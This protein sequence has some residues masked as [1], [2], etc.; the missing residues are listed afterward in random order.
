MASTF[1]TESSASAELL[2]CI[3]EG[4]PWPDYLLRRAL[5]EDEG[6]QLFSVVIERL[7]D[8]FEPALCDEYASLFT[9]VV[10]L[11]R[12]EWK[13]SDLLSRYERVRRIRRCEHTNVRDVFVLSR[14]TLGADV[15][16][17]SVILDAL[18]RR[19]PDANI[20]FTGPRK[21][22]EL[23]AGNRRI[24]HAPYPYPRAGS[25][26][27]RLEKW[28]PINAPDSIVVDPDSRLT[29]LG[30]LPF[31]SEE[32]YFF[33]ESRAWQADSD[34]A[35][36]QLASAWCNEVFGEAGRA[37]AVPAKYARNPGRCC[38]EPGSW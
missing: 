22:F 21:N 20:H 16:V 38:R 37:M 17:T 32:D 23:F 11:L 13:G 25:L 14:V 35:L 19:F 1:Q 9:R 18:Q 27:E 34:L 12:P 7:G 36:P 15:A 28:E 5:I 6:R 4:N 24:A 2:T 3:L 26:A 33:F 30:I 10:E 31:C 8:L 29:Q